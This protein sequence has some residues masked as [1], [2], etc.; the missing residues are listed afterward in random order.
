MP[1]SP[2]WLWGREM[3]SALEDVMGMVWVDAGEGGRLCIPREE[4]PAL[5]AALEALDIPP[6]TGLTDSDAD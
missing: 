6:D 2:S 3:V 1:L 5:I 4:V